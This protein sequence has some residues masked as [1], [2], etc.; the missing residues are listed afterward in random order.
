MIE[1]KQFTDS[2]SKVRHRKASKSSA[3]LL[4]D[5]F[6]LPVTSVSDEVSSSRHKSTSCTPDSRTIMSYWMKISIDRELTIIII[7]KK[8][9]R[10]NVNILFTFLLLD[11]TILFLNDET[12]HF[13][14]VLTRVEQKLQDL[15]RKDWKRGWASLALAT[16]IYAK[17]VVGAVML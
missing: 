6:Q 7:K 13:D 3:Q 11:F 2:V 4:P 10:L 12:W 5:S 9:P 16:K 8:Y 15:R 14:N 17:K 1:W